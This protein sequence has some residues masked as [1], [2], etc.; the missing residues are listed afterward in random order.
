VTITAN[1]WWN[2]RVK[3][4]GG[5]ESKKLPSVAEPSGFQAAR[6]YCH[7]LQTYRLAV[8]TTGDYTSYHRSAIILGP[9]VA[10]TTI[11]SVNQI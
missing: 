5:V 6:S 9:S 7:N 4:R 8:A 10:T 2:R 1:A 11:D 3:R